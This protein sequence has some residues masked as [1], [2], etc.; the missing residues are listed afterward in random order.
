MRKESTLNRV[1]RKTTA[2]FGGAKHRNGPHRTE[3]W[4]V[5][6][7]TSNIL[8]LAPNTKK[9]AKAPRARKA[10]AVRPL[11]PA[12]LAALRRQH[13]AAAA[14]AVLA[15]SLPFLSVHHLATG[16]LARH[17]LRGVRD[18]DKRR[19]YRLRLPAAG[20][21]AADNGARTPRCARWRA[22]PIRP[23]AS[24]SPAAQRSTATQLCRARPGRWR[25]SPRC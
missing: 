12:S 25:S 17:A 20:A 16:Y 3:Q 2:R 6:M 10:P 21:G 24:R 7:A 13:V 11:K 9:T 5:Q 15:G 8:P 18:A 23:S 22:G 19:G 4:V 14:V 1:A